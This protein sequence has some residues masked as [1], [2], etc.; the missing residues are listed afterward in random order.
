M[1]Q[2][3]AALA[4]ELELVDA[5]LGIHKIRMGERLSF[6]LS[7]PASLV[8]VRIPTM[9]LLTLVEN[10]LKHGINPTVEGGH[11][12]VSAV[13]ERGALVLRV[14]DSGRGMT[15]TEGH[16]LGLANIRQ[17]LTMYYGERALL[18]LSAAESGGV[19]ASVS[20]PL[21]DAV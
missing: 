7:A 15:A 2:E 18:A 20:I 19:M 10:A 1:R 17:R 4:E 13:Q 12:R 8:G 6:E 3:Q 9:I 14:I 21:A 5:Y 16:G 11:I